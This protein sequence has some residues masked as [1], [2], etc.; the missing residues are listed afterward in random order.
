MYISI[1][2]INVINPTIIALKIL[3]ANPPI[4]DLKANLAG[5][6]FM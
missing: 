5:V 6:F 1:F 2:Y 3:T 4:I